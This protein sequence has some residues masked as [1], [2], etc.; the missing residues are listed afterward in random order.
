[1]DDSSLVRSLMIMRY[2]ANWIS[3]VL[4]HRIL[5]ID[6]DHGRLIIKCHST[7][8]CTINQFTSETSHV[9]GST[10]V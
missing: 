3:I 2:R 5:R 6:G 1:M 7:L 4:I 10:Q 8:T 9:V